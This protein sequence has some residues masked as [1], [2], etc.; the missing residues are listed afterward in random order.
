MR[1]KLRL[2]NQEIEFTLR[3]SRLA[4]R[5]RLTIY[6]D[7]RIAVS[8]PKYASIRKIESFMISKADWILERLATAASNPPTL[9]LLKHSPKEIIALKKQAKKLVDS[10]ITELNKKYKFTFGRISIRN[11]KSRWGS[12]SKKGN[13]NFNYRIALLP[14]EQ[15]DYIIVHELCHLKEFNHSKN[16]WELVVVAAPEYKRIKKELQTDISAGGLL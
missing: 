2:K 13:L 3:Q 10:R 9:R 1:Y 14:A 15:A 5:L 4:K 12:C 7:G 8:A 11:Q 6:E 16:F